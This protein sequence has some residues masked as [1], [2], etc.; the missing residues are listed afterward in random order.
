MLAKTVF[1]QAEHAGGRARPLPGGSAICLAD[2]VAWV[3]PTVESGATVCVHAARRCGRRTMG[4]SAQVAEHVE[5]IAASVD[6]AWGR[7]FPM[8]VP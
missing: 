5:G 7:A 3:V 1:C 8:T 2:C 4:T 6:Q